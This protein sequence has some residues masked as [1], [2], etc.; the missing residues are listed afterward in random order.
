VSKPGASRL[1]FLSRKPSG[2]QIERELAVCT[3]CKGQLD[4]GVSYDTL[5]NQRGQEKPGTT[6]PVPAPYQPLVNQ[7]VT[8]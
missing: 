7:P 6:A 3:E 8:F 2:K 1:L 5:I 4:Q